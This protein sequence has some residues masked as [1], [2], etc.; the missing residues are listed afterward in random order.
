[1]LSMQQHSWIQG[2]R[3]VSKL[4]VAT[5]HVARIEL[6]DTDLRGRRVVKTLQYRVSEHG[7]EEF[8][9]D[10]TNDPELM[11]A[12][13]QR[14]GR[15]RFVARE[16]PPQAVR[17]GE[18]KSLYL[19]SCV[20]VQRILEGAT[21]DRVRELLFEALEPGWT[22]VAVESPFIGRCSLRL[23]TLADVPRPASYAWILRGDDRLPAISWS[24]L[25]STVPF[26][27]DPG[28]AELLSHWV[29]GP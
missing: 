21:A 25:A 20:I 1:M 13:R 4:D 6:P 3:A 27:D 24:N 2:R 11:S 18:A 16:P 15:F 23:P 26:R 5:I 14:G 12:I 19:A 7:T 28:I 9:L 17:L 8:Y 22:P 29:E 10:P